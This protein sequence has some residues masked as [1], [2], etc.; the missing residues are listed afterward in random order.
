M[1]GINEVECTYMNNIIPEAA[2]KRR[3]GRKPV[4]P[5]RGLLILRCKSN[6]PLCLDLVMFGRS[7]F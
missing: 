4:S 5:G 6:P 7:T 2:A 3:S 1:L